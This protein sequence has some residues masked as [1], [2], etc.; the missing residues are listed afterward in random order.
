M[1]FDSPLVEWDVNL[2]TIPVTDTGKEV[3][4]NFQSFEI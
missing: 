2:E 3:T 1:T 4:V